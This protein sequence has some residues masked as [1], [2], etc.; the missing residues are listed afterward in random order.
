IEEVAANMQSW[1]TRGLPSLHISLNQSVAQ[2]SSSECHVKWLDILK[3]KQI[4]PRSITFE[5]SEKVFFEEKNNYLN[6]IEKLKKE[7]IQ[8]SLD[9]FGTGYSS[10]SYLKKFPV[11]VI[12]IDR[13]YIHTMIDDPTNA[14]L[15]ETIILLA[16]KLGIKVIATGVE[17]KEQLALLKQQCRYAQGY[18]FSKP[19]P[20]SE[21]EAFMEMHNRM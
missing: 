4:S 10:L 17:N 12:K 20:L 1:A 3:K 7:G 11:D 15:V 19:L 16:N 21:F 14:I 18:Y 2:Y 8:I 9:S 13:S 6:S 5:I